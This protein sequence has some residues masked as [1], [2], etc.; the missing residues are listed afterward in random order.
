MRRVVSH[1]LIMG[2]F[3]VTF[4]SSVAGDLEHWGEYGISRKLNDCF[5]LKS[6]V[7]I[8]VR[9][10]ISDFYWARF[11][12]GPNFKIDKRWLSMTVY[13]RVK[14]QEYGDEWKNQYNLMFD[15]VVKL[16]SGKST[17]VDFRVRVHTQLNDDNRRQFV[18]FR[19]RVT[20]RF[21]LGKTPC[22]WYACNDFWLQYSSLGARD[23]YNTNWAATGCRFGLCKTVDFTAYFQYRSDK[24]PTTG[25][26]DH[27]PVIGTSVQFK[28]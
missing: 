4:G 28:L 5:T 13:F 12:I 6:D 1:L 15:P 21:K 19:P 2:L 23:R 27:D 25:K 7:Q 26:W 8:R 20:H 14:R 9:E 17:T 11:E 24:L 18:R 3:F 16:Y 22:A 10:D